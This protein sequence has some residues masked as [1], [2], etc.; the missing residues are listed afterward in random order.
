[1]EALDM[2]LSYIDIYHVSPCFAEAGKVSVQARLSDDITEIMPYLNRVVKNASYNHNA[3]NVTMFKEFR[4]ITIEP[5]EIILIKALNYTDARQVIVWLKDLINDT[6]ERMDDME[7]LYK[8]KKRPHPLQIYS[9]LPRNNCGQCG[10]KS[11][12]AFAALL[13]VGQ[14]RIEKC[15][16]LFTDDY[17][18]QREVILNLIEIL[19]HDILHL[20]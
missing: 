10:E 3:P 7:P 8:S 2:Y 14:Q 1:M 13:S 16:P 20:H 19:G 17:H 12:I 9:W 5:K 11:C 4:M 15:E 6:A 18:E